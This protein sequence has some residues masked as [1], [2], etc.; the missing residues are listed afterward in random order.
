MLLFTSFTIFIYQFS[1]KATLIILHILIVSLLN[2]GNPIE[3]NRSKS[4]NAETELRKKQ[5]IQTL[6]N[7]DVKLYYEE[8]FPGKDAPPRKNARVNGEKISGNYVKFGIQEIF[9]DKGWSK[10]KYVFRVIPYIKGRG[11]VLRFIIGQMQLFQNDIG[12]KKVSLKR[13]KVMTQT[14][15]GIGG[16]TKMARVISTINQSFRAIVHLCYGIFFI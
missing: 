10:K 11:M 14:A 7:S 4:N 13:L 6:E 1:M 16:G 3:E 15:S 12:M 9:V 5:L 8:D 2:A